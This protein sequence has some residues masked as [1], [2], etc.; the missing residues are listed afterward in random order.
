M[1]SL[2]E[3]HSPPP[4][5][6]VIGLPAQSVSIR[7][8]SPLVPPELRRGRIEEIRP[9]RWCGLPVTEEQSGGR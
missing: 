3:V 4:K 5:D 2:E 8:F 1:E 7:C 9:V 6:P